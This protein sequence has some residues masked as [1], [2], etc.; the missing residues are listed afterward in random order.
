MGAGLLT[1]TIAGLIIHIAGVVTRGF[2]VHRV[3]WGDMYEFVIAAS[4]VAVLFF[5][6]LMLRYRPYRLGLFFMAP[7]VIIM[8]LAQTVIYTPAGPLVPGAE[9]LLAG[10]PRHLDH[11][12]LRDVRGGGRAGGGVPGRGAA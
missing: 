12:G 7:I 3:P 4:C 11:P 6:G 9:L 5:V 10:H 8:G 1:A 2:A